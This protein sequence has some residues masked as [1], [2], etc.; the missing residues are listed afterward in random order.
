[1]AHFAE[2][3]ESNVVVRVLVVPDSEEHRGEEYLARDLG[4][5]GRWVQTS[6]NHNI[7]GRCA[8]VGDTYDEVSDEFIPPPPFPS[9]ADW[10]GSEWIAPVPKPEV[11]DWGWDEESLSWVEIIPPENP[12][13]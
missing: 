6:Y 10:N 5:G 9:W 11:G 13:P 3:D 2:I 1:M 8:G 4:L 12:A 7:R